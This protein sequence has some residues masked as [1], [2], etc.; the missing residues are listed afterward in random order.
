LQRTGLSQLEIK[1][2][3][4][5]IEVIILQTLNKKIAEVRI[6]SYF[7]IFMAITNYT[8]LLVLWNF[9]ITWTKMYLKITYK[10]LEVSS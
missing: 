2:D 4:A 10:I 3:V 6:F 8:L 1:K 5:F 9:K 7:P